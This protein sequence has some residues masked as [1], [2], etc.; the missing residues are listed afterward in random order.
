M[1]YIK[2]TI[3]TGQDSPEDIRK[4]IRMLQHL[5]GESAY[6]NQGNIFSDDSSDA[7]SSDSSD[8]SNG[9]N[10]FSAMFG[11]DG[12]APVSQEET[13]SLDEEKTEE[14]KIDMDSEIIPY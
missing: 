5:V 12:P 9:S 2:I 10:A 13:S 8:E 6:S 3:D 11:D 7:P 1:I 14:K 4:V